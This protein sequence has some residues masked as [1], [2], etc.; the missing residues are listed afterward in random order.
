MKVLKLAI[1]TVLAELATPK[2]DSAK[3]IRLC[4]GS[5]SVLDQALLCEWLE[6]KGSGQQIKKLKE[7]VKGIKDGELLSAVMD[8]T[9]VC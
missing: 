7:K 4:G 2:E 6:M 3:I 5:V 1:S 9:V 8:T